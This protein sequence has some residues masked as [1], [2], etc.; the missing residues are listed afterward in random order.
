[1]KDSVLK[2]EFNNKDVQRLRNLIKKDYNSATSIQSG[3]NKINGEHFEG[4]IWEENG[5]KWTINNGIKQNITKLNTFKDMYFMPLTCPECNVPMN[6]HIDK[7]L[8]NIHKKCS[9]CVI[10]FETQL[11]IQGKYKEYEKALISNNIEYFLTEYKKFI[12]TELDNVNT[13]FITEAGDI[14]KWKGKIDKDRIIKQSNEFIEE[15]SKYL[16]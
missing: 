4:D 1:M 11:K 9:T 8:Y 7:K 6:K 13:N 5:K 16:K 2:K 3:Y 12:E 10:E 15:A 14:E